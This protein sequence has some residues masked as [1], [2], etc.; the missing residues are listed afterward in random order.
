MD[1]PGF[2]IR[3]DMPMKL[4]QHVDADGNLRYSLVPKFENTTD[5]I[6]DKDVNVLNVQLLFPVEV[7]TEDQSNNQKT[8]H[9]SVDSVTEPATPSNKTVCF[10]C[11]RC[12]MKFPTHSMLNRHKITHTVRYCIFEQPHVVKTRKK[13]RMESVTEKTGEKNLKTFNCTNC[14]YECSSEEDLG[15]HTCELE[16]S[17]TNYVCDVCNYECKRSTTLTAHMVQFHKS[18]KSP[19]ARI[20]EKRATSFR[21]SASVSHDSSDVTMVKKEVCPEE[22]RGETSQ[23][24][25]TDTTAE[26][27]SFIR[28]P[29]QLLCDKC[30][31]KCTN[32]STLYSHKQRRHRKRARSVV[33]TEVYSCD[34][35]S[36]KTTKKS[37]LS[38]HIYRKHRDPPGGVNAEPELF[39]CS[40]CDYKNKNKYEL[41]IHVARKHTEDFKY[42]CETCGKR[43]KVKGDLTN[44]IRFNH[45]EQ[46]VICDV[47]GKTCLNSNSLYVHQKFAHYKAK[48]ECHLCKRRMVSQENL[49][50][51]MLR[52][53]ER[54]ENVVCE[55][56]GKTF[57]RNSRL[58][59]HMRIHTGDKPYPC[60]ICSKSFARRTALKQHLL[61]H[62][63]IRP[64]VCDICGKA[65]TQKPGLI[66][67]RKSHPGP[68][69][70]LPRVLI[71]HI[72]SNVMSNT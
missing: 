51:H 19:N 7:K 1:D 68:H 43:Y 41:K 14:N 24:A 31:F 67:H 27:A 38:S 11:N 33:N 21:K 69:P 18:E 64:Y 22:E 15:N 40:Q 61:I 55:E 71:D 25:D 59:I 28:Q 6:I 66:S 34:V 72:L 50:E 57:S 12:N 37:S 62:T 44:H 47:C 45:R 4:Y 5:T 9:C 30:D 52:Q 60:T 53:H 65:F 17:K 35:C 58:K 36:F 23:D 8:D 42:S 10:A 26:L 63:G 54:R 13:K 2:V 20:D 56:C 3:K 48:Y 46:P 49:D 32:K 29:H 70:P 39:S 16:K